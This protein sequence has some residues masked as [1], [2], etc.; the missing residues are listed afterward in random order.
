MAHQARSGPGHHGLQQGSRTICGARVEGFRSL[1]DPAAQCLRAHGES[2]G[3]KV[4]NPL[5]SIPTPH[6]PVVRGF[7][8][9]WISEKK[10]SLLDARALQHRRP[11]LM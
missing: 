6:S 10:I 4:S 3:L 7:G 9:G 11:E 2:L 1:M 8:G 5:R